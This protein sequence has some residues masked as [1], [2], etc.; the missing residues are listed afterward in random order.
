MLKNPEKYNKPMAAP[1]VDKDG[2]PI[3]DEEGGC[4]IQ[5]KAEFVVKT[6]VSFKY[7]KLQD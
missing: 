1:Q 3:L 6:K 2:K 7:L 4:V 5:P